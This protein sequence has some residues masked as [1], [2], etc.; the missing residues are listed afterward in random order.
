M[1]TIAT[2]IVRRTATTQKNRPNADKETVKEVNHGK[3]KR[4]LRHFVTIRQVVIDLPDD[5]YTLSKSQ[6][7]F[8]ILYQP[9]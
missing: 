3:P 2:V 8:V 7:N 1:K 6:T 9:T 4:S 5:L